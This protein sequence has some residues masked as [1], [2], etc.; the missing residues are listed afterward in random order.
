[1]VATEETYIEKKILFDAN[2]CVI[3]YA[4]GWVTDSPTL[5]QIQKQIFPLV[6][7]C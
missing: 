7:H 1:M 6:T 2:G 5:L 3:F 4:D